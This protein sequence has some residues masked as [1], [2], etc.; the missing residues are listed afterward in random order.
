MRMDCPVTRRDFLRFGTVVV[1]GL[2]LRAPISAG[3]SRRAR[4]RACILLYMDGGASHIDLWDMKPDAPEEIRGEFRSIG[5]SVPG[6]RV[7]EHL[8]RSAGQMHRITQI[9]SVRHAE[10]V[11]DPAVYQM[12]TG[13]KH[14]SSAGDL[15]VQPSDFPQM[16]TAFGAVERTPGAMPKVIEL[17]ETMKMGGR[18]LPGQNAGFLGAAYDPFR[19]EVTPAARVV[20]PEFALASDMPGSR[21]HQRASLLETLERRPITALVG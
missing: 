18:I 15:T 13:R 6:I 8:P 14:L 10:T 11:H 4:A 2:G 16:G 12:L 3:P 1:G 9:R 5:T 19:V 20:Q 17:P 21:L 7:C